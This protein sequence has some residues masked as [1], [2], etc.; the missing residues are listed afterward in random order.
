MNRVTSAMRIRVDSEDENESDTEEEDPVDE[1]SS[2]DD[3]SAPKNAKRSARARTNRKAT[4]SKAAEQTLAKKRT[5][6]TSDNRGWGKKE[7]PPPPLPTELGQEV[8][9]EIIEAIKEPYICMPPNH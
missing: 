5:R 3:D 4:A 6:K 2:S 9:P 7:G 8:P 1:E